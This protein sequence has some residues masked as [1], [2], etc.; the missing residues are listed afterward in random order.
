MKSP[1]GEKPLDGYAILVVCKHTVRGRGK[2]HRFTELGHRLNQNLYQHGEHSE[3][4][5][6]RKAFMCPFAKESALWLR[7]WGHKEGFRSGHL[8]VYF[9]GCEVRKSEPRGSSWPCAVLTAAVRPYTL[10]TLASGI[11]LRECN[12]TLEENHSCCFLRSDLTDA[13]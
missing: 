11:G 9:S 12:R 10:D 6:S 8:T 13:T 4:F 7:R 1:V 5:E 3:G 2:R